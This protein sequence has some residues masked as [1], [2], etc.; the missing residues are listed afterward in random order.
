MTKRRPPFRLCTCEPEGMMRGLADIVAAAGC[1]EKR[2]FRVSNL[3]LIN[4]ITD[5]VETAIPADLI[6]RRWR[7]GASSNDFSFYTGAARSR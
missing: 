5:A 7:L 1:M 2:Q 4:L 3:C 6:V